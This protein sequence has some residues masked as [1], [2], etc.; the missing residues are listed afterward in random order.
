MRAKTA[1]LTLAMLACSVL[2]W[3]AGK[4]LLSTDAESMLRDALSTSSRGEVS[5]A[6][7][8]IESSLLTDGVKVA[9]RDEGS[10]Y[11]YAVREA[12]Q[13]WNEAL[14]DSPFVYT[15]DRRKADVVVKFVDKLTDGF[16]VQGKVEAER[17]FQWNRRSSSYKL[18]AEITVCR[19]V[20]YRFLDD[21]EV[22]EVVAH[23]L[24]HLLGLDDTDS[25]RGL[26]GPF[27]P[28]RARTRPLREEVQAVVDYRNELRAALDRLAARG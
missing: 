17:R 3:A 27:D 12:I 19:R 23:E 2:A 14:E 13:V 11:R 6:R 1:F 20:D 26:M 15:S 8:M 9:L 22:T 24:G 10:D 4:G 28:G 5:K 7:A 18:V 21:E 16:D 25:M